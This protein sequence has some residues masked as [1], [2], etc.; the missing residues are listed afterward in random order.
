MKESIRMAAELAAKRQHRDADLRLRLEQASA[1]LSGSDLQL[2]VEELVDNACSF[3]AGG[4]PVEVR[5][6]ADGHLSIRDEGRGMD[7][8]C[9]TG[10][11]SRFSRP[12]K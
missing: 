5:L 3:S 11:S 1:W 10:P 9:S 12:R 8:R 2:I 6:E 4:C 7:V